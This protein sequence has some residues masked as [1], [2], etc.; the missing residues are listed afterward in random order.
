DDAGDVQVGAN[1]F[2]RPADLVRLI[3]LETM[4]REPVFMRIDRHRSH[5]E[6]MRR[7]KDADR[8]FAAVGDQEFTDRFWHGWK[9][10]TPS[11]LPHCFPGYGASASSHPAAV[12]RASSLAK[13]LATARHRSLT[14]GISSLPSAAARCG[15]VRRRALNQVP[16]PSRSTR[17]ALSS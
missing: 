9:S 17:A 4:Q 5:A 13:R 1:R 16:A 7:A 11:L 3:R 2:A 15:A 10:F 8:D 12:S 14:S 6:F